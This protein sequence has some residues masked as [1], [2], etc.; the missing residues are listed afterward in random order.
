MAE[1]AVPRKRLKEI[2]TEIAALKQ[3]LT[4]LKAEREQVKAQID[5]ARAKNASKSAAKPA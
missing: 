5:A 2:K 1:N 4:T 3:K